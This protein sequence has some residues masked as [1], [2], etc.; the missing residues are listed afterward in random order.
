MRSRWLLRA[1]M[2]L[3]LCVMTRTAQ[4]QYRDRY[5]L[6]NGGIPDVMGVNIH[7]NDPKPGE[8]E[9]LAGAGFRWIRQDFMWAGI[10]REKGR[11]DFA[12]YDRLMA[13]LK[14]FG[15]RPIFIL[16]Y[17][18]DLYQQGSPNTPETR[19]AFGRF[20]A[21]AV[22]HFKGQGVVWEMWNE[23]NIGFWKPKPN[24]DEYVALAL[25]T[26]KAIRSAAPDEW[27][28]GPGMSGMDFPFLQ[29]CL[30]AGLLKYW[31]AISFH[32]YRDTPPETA[33]PD[34]AHVRELIERY[35]PPGKRVPILNSEW[36]Y[37]ELYPGLNRERQSWYIVR[38]TLTNLIN[39]LRISIWY[40][41]Q[42][43]GIDTKEPE[44][45]FGTVFNDYRGKETYRSAQTLSKT[46][47]GFTYNKRLALNSPQDYCLLFLR[48][49]EVRLAA[50]TTSRTPHSVVLP[51]STGKFQVI[52]Y[53]GAATE[54]IA[55]ADGLPV[56]LTEA[57][58]YIVPRTRDPLLTM[59]AEWSV[60]P[61]YV[62][63]GDQ[64]SFNT[65]LELSGIG[66][67]EAGNVTLLQADGADP[68][69]NEFKSVLT[70]P[71]TNSKVI[72]I[73]S[74]LTTLVD[75]SGT[76]HR[77]RAVLAVRGRKPIAQETELV[78]RDPIVVTAL[79]PFDKLLPVQIDNISAKVLH[80]LL[81]MRVNDENHEIAVDFRKGETA[82]RVDVP[83]ARSPAADAT[84]RIDLEDR[85]KPVAAALVT[86]S[87]LRFQ[88]LLSF[89][90]SIPEGT[91]PEHST[92]LLPDGDPKVS[93]QLDIRR[94][95]APAGLPA[96][97]LDAEK[98]SYDFAPGWK[99]LRVAPQGKL[100]ESL[101]GEPDRLGMWIYSD[102]SGNLLRA[103]FID[104]T[105]QTFQPDGG[106]LNFQGWRYITFPLH[107]G[108]GHWGGAN[109]NKVHYPIRLDTVLLIDTPDQ[110]GTKGE[111]YFTNVVLSYAAER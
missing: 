85:A 19:A 40:D 83:L 37:S 38:Q 76:P 89:T 48:G 78:S 98:V 52:S 96:P 94:V 32:P 82:K 5:P 92:I 25:E 41:W 99:F 59:A 54:G 1:G 105:G 34:F 75:R 27:F 72:R 58:V 88:S 23:P 10:E 35:A 17:G 21:A 91:A 22:T 8:M 29:R 86:L 2:L 30:Q 110:K 15:I 45:H 100:Q 57:P 101:S 3:L 39:G 70:M 87:T 63:Y 6:P 68:T 81:R 108:G 53:L 106:T 11:Y 28:V 12:A 31:D 80:A 20:A 84:V 42:D 65:L 13:H 104:A 43:D 103:R 67:R 102:G 49:A 47:N 97:T 93:S 90:P 26:G 69:A 111:V 73:P 60:L 62:R 77:Y 109:D 79:A 9:Q 46:L 51:T 33:S 44:H 61:P 64:E 107:P 95:T 66:G 16:D 71:L 74:N 4:A 36:G 18:N 50:W 55:T 7:F 14:R 24:W 56:T